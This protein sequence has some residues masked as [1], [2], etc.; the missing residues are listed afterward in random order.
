MPVRHKGDVGRL[1]QAQAQQFARTLTRISLCGA[2][3][4]THGHTGARRR[5]Q[6]AEGRRIV[7]ARARQ[8][9]TAPIRTHDLL[10]EQTSAELMS[11]H[12]RQLTDVHADEQQDL[13]YQG[14]SG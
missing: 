3:S 7:G 12:R 13:L 11:E 1:R 5:L 14:L 4:R 2:F 8:A 10:T 6:G 9:V